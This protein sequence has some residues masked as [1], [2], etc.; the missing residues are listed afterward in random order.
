MFNRADKFICFSY[1]ATFLVFVTITSTGSYNPLQRIKFDFYQITTEFSWGTKGKHGSWRI[2]RFNLLV[3]I[4]LIKRF[5]NDVIKFFKR[6]YIT[7]TFL[8]FLLGR[9]GKW[10]FVISISMKPSGLPLCKNHDFIS[11]L[12]QI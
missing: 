1:I 8:D 2:N 6:W 9:V 7:V 5:V 11:Y 12:W 4:K 10:T 3:Y